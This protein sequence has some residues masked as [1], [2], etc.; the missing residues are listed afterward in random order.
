MK[1]KIKKGD[2]VAIV[3]LS[4]GKEFTLKDFSE[5]DD[6][7]NFMISQGDGYFTFVIYSLAFD[8]Y[9]I[10]R[11]RYTDLKTYTSLALYSDL[12]GTK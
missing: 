7:I 4:S 6:F 5:K 3:S 2:T 10:S 12:G 1:K 9:L 11:V 8:S